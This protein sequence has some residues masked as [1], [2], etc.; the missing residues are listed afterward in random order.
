MKKFT[1]I[2]AV[3]ALMASSAMAGS[4]TPGVEDPFIEPVVP[5][6]SSGSLGGSTGAIIAGVAAAALIAAA[7]ASDDD[8]DNTTTTTTE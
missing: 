1:T 7:V 2:A 5:V 8:D 6:G 3:A 4:P